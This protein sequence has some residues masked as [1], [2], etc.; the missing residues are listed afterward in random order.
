MNEKK[1]S[2]PPKKKGMTALAILLALLLAAGGVIAYRVHQANVSHADIVLWD[3]LTT[4][5]DAYD[6]A[7][8]AEWQADFAEICDKGYFRS[9]LRRGFQNLADVGLENQR[10]YYQR[11]DGHWEAQA[12][13]M[14]GGQGTCSTCAYIYNKAVAVLAREGYEDPELKDIALDFFQREKQLIQD[15]AAALTEKNGS[16]AI[17]SEFNDA[18]VFMD[19]WNEAGGDFYAL[20]I[21]QV[22]TAADVR[23]SYAQ[24]IQ[25]CVDEGNLTR[26]TN[27]LVTTSTSPLMRDEPFFTTQEILDIYTGG[28]QEV[29]TLLNGVGG[30]YSGGANEYG[31]FYFSSTSYRQG[32][33]TFDMTEFNANP[34][35]WNSIGPELRDYIRST[36]RS[37]NKTVYDVD[38][39]I[40]DLVTPRGFDV[41]AMVKEGFGYAIPYEGKDG[42][43]FIFVSPDA[44]ALSG[45]IGNHTLYGD[46]SDLYEEL[47][48]AYES[49]G[50]ADLS[51]YADYTGVFT[52]QKDPSWTFSSAFSAAGGAVQWVPSLAPGSK[53]L[54]FMTEEDGKEYEFLNGPRTV[55]DMQVTE[56]FT[57]S[58]GTQYQ[59]V[60]QFRDGAIQFR[61]TAAWPDGGEDS[62]ID[63]YTKTG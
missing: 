42:M 60:L 23:D 28:T 46:Y 30:Y 26:L 49:G 9:A 44:M 53:Y 10:T 6:E 35:L 16:N 17:A 61:L 25:D 37:A 47:K 8:Y 43:D 12:E 3:L 7:K 36:N 31:D 32:G 59:A 24:A 18:A 34:G 48:A 15:N 55:E 38:F 14:F 63:T 50:S 1:I 54:P 29:Y 11:G 27:L 19:H 45:G 22:Y 40:R 57:T 2:N 21:S 51:A 33:K 41:P 56:A 20:D 5:G 39:R 58:G 62:F 13:D 52:S 4:S